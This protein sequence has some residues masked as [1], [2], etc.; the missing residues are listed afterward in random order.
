MVHELLGVHVEDALG[1]IPAAVGVV[2][3]E[4]GVA[5][6]F[7]HD[8]I[9][10]YVLQGGLAKASGE[11]PEDWARE[12][13]EKGRPG[14]LK[15]RDGPVLAWEGNPQEEGD[16]RE[17]RHQPK[18]HLE[19]KGIFADPFMAAASHLRDI[20]LRPLSLSLTTSPVLIDTTTVFV[21]HL[22][23]TPFVRPFSMTRMASF[24][25]HEPPVV[26]Y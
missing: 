16:D 15:D 22:G 8:T 7:C 2:T 9:C 10:Y 11:F 17:G 25:T 21:P 19:L 20:P 23:F 26:L 4:H 6:A 1:P 24:R 12:S 13:G 14:T 5:L 18:G 3:I